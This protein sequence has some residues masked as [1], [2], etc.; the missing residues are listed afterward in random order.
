MELAQGSRRGRSSS[1]GQGSRPEVKGA[2]AIC[3][4]GRPPPLGG[5]PGTGEADGREAGGDALTLSPRPSQSEQELRV[6]QTEFDRQAEVTRLLL[7]GISSTHVSPVPPPV[8]PRVPT[9]LVH[10]EAGMNLEAGG[11]GLCSMRGNLAWGEQVPR[12]GTAL[13]PQG[14]R[15]GATRP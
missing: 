7:E 11:E 4:G 13:L 9:D 6:A 14:A 5:P 12:V 3:H 2:H 1:R 10:N 8:T 15:G